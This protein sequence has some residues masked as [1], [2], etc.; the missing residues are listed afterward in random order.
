MKIAKSGS[1]ISILMILG[2]LSVAGLGTFAYFNDV[3]TVGTNTITA[4]TLDLTI[5]GENPSTVQINVENVYPG[6][7]SICDYTITNIGS[8]EGELTVTVSAITNMENGLT[9]PEVEAGDTTEDTGELGD[10]LKLYVGIWEGTRLLSSKEVELY[11]WGKNP[12]WIPYDYHDPMSMLGGSSYTVKIK[13]SI[14]SDVGNVIQSDSVDFD[15]EFR[16]DQVI[17]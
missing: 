9:E 11:K 13:A 3:E 4:G 15:I 17:P 2:M 5:N 1:L 6:W 7:F 10:Y 14:P 12:T 8:L 16:L